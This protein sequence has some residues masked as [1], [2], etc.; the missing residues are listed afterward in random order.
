MGWPTGEKQGSEQLRKTWHTVVLVCEPPS[1][2]DSR[3]LGHSPHEV[4]HFIIRQL[5]FPEQGVT[6]E[7]G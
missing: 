2:L 3:R 6:L 7:Y 4:T 1:R 5:A